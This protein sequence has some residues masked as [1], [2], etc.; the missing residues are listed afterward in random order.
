MQKS[1]MV[2]EDWIRPVVL[3]LEHQNSLEGFLQ[4]KSLDPNP[5]V[6]DSVCLGVG[7]KNLHFSQVS[8]CCWITL[9]DALL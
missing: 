9:C 4:H 5:R 1:S 3:K 6:S 2:L 7:P 8:R